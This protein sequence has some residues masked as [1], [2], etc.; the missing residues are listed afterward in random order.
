MGFSVVLHFVWFTGE[1]R[2]RDMWDLKSHGQSNLTYSSSGFR[3][4]GRDVRYL[5]PLS[6]GLI[7]GICFQ[8]KYW[9]DFAF[10]S[11]SVFHL[12]ILLPQIKSFHF[13]QCSFCH[14]LIG[15][16]SPHP[17][18][19]VTC[20]QSWRSCPPSLHS[21]ST[22]HCSAKSSCNSFGSKLGFLLFFLSLVCCLSW[23]L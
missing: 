3:K 16:C 11:L 9:S 18:K 12:L 20:D 19:I 8:I 6:P 22:R 21:E 1:L 13:K 15:R 5:D 10:S 2:L 4:Y 23:N 14:I 17:H 7:P